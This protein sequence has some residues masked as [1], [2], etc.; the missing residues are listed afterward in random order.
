[1]TLSSMIGERGK[2]INNNIWAHQVINHHLRILR[3]HHSHSLVP[4]LIDFIRDAGVHKL[5]ERLQEI[6]NSASKEFS[7]EKAM[8][9]MKGEWE[10]VSVN[11]IYSNILER[12][13]I[14]WFPVALEYLW[15]ISCTEVFGRCVQNV[16]KFFSHPE[17]SLVWREICGGR[18]LRERF[19][20][21]PFSALAL[22]HC[23]A[24]FS[25]RRILSPV[26]QK[27][28]A[29]VQLQNFQQ[30]VSFHFQPEIENPQLL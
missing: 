28:Y 7:L 12:T 15:Y 9:K 27:S 25:F 6:S 30:S 14:G 5:G 11:T 22:S 23:I 18:L 19:L 10:H 16:C 13:S 17:I 1:M 2:I 26:R 3:L 20:L 29:C 24:S 8:A 4:V 21:C